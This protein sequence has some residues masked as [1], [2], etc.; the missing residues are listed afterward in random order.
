[1]LIFSPTANDSPGSG[2]DRAHQ[3]LEAY[4]EEATGALR[5]LTNAN[6]KGLLRR[7][8]GKIFNDLQIEGW[9][10]EFEARNASGG[11]G[12]AGAPR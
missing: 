4:K 8:V 1:M 2:L 11:A 9:C 7:V 12:G 10:R 5:R 3:L 6:L